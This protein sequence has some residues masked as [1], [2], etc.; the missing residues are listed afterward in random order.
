MQL[1]PLAY[2]S[3]TTP[4]LGVSPYEMFFNQKPRKPIMFTA[5]SSMCYNLPL[6]T[7]D[8]DHL[9]HPQTLKLASDT[10]TEWILNRDKKNYEINQNIAKKLIAKQNNHHQMNSRF[11]PATN[12][13]IGTFVLMRN[14]VIQKRI[15][16]KITTNPKTTISNY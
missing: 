11:T 15:S 16:K 3:Q 7:H 8:E 14:V 6:H 9:H 12:L 2:N 4:N 5:Y 10:H 1:F 13:K